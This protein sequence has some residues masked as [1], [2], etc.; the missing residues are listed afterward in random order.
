LISKSITIKRL[1]LL[2]ILLFSIYLGYL[3]YLVKTEF[4][5]PL[6][7][8]HSTL[9]LEQHPKPLLNMLLLVEDQSFFKHPGVDFKEIARV[10]RDYW[11]H[12]KPI[13]G[14][15][16]LTQQL[17]KN[18]L[19]TR[20]QTVSRKLNEVLMALLLE[21]SFDKD[22]ILNRYINTLYLAQQGNKAIYGFEKGAQFYF[23]QPIESLSD[24]EMATL[25]ALIK[26]PSY[27]HPI[28]HAQRLAKRRQL[29]L[30]IYY[31]FEKIVK[32]SYDEFISH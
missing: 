1:M 16:T 18:T 20:E 26:G 21:V 22:F 4:S 11:I 7:S 8:I 10:L 6:E 30:S 29:V 2:G 24:E 23:N 17:I 14:A 9:S 13:R 31:K 5:K 3:N 15:S 25:V 27:Y 32:Q 28:K 12:D 19:L